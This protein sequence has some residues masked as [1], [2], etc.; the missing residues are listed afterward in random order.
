[1]K[2]AL[3]QSMSKHSF[4][5]AVPLLIGMLSLTLTNPALAQETERMMRTIT[6]TGQGSE[7]IPTTLTQ[8]QLGVEVQGDTAEAVQKEAAQRSAAVVEFL[9]SRNVGKLQTAGISLNPRYDYDNGQQRIVGYTATNSVSFR[10]PTEQ[11]GGLLDQA[12]RAGATRI[13]GVTFAADDAAMATARQQAIR[14]AT[15]EA[16]AQAEAALSALGLTRREVVSIQVNGAPMPPPVP[17]FRQANYAA[18]AADSAPT[19]VIGGE[20]EVEATVTLQ[21]SY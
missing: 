3:T 7:A 4:R 12:V 5:A 8:V 18:A 20:Q 19:P 1:M 9:R 13:D 11:A 6:V 15:Q 10:V 14:E 17:L 21:I 2:L 16:Q